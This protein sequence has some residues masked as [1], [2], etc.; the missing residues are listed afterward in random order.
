MV[1]LKA[2]EVPRWLEKGSYRVEA[3]LEGTTERL[4]CLQFEIKLK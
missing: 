1:N 2:M 4:L 3:K